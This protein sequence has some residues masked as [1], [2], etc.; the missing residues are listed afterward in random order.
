M[1]PENQVITL[2]GKDIEWPGMDPAAGKF[3]NGNFSNPEEKPSY[4]P[5]QTV[6]LILDNLQNFI[7]GLGLTPNNTDP[8]QLLTA[9]QNKY[10]TKEW[11]ADTFLY[12]GEMVLQL[13]GEKSP[14]EAGWPGSWENWSL[15]TVI[16]GLAP[17]PPPQSFSADFAAKGA[18]VWFLNTDGSVATQGTKKYSY[19]MG[20]LYQERI[21]CGNALPDEDWETEYQI[22][23]PASLYNGYYIWEPIHLGGT[24]PS[25]EDGGVNRPP[26]LSGGV[27]GDMMRDH[28]HALR[29]GYGSVVN[30]D[31]QTVG[32]AGIQTPGS[33]IPNSR[34]GDTI[35]P[36]SVTVFTGPQNSPVTASVRVW[37][38]L[39][40]IPG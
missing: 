19:P 6:N 14:V 26:F 9:L 7:A 3:T 40:D 27:M 30:L 36:A 15:R 11:F 37:R 12:P 2:F 22:N 8:N 24:F 21:M 10:G 17:T 16:Y 39:P 1:Y 34:L 5:A 38:R 35:R 32:I 4:I 31:S 28:N 13:P 29:G 23:D 33:F 20:Y 18:S 25:F